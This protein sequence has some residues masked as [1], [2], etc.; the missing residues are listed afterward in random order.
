MTN[1]VRYIIVLMLF[2][3]VILAQD[4]ELGMKV[5]TLQVKGRVLYRQEGQGPQPLKW[6]QPIMPNY[7]LELGPDGYL[8][9]A[10]SVRLGEFTGPRMLMF[11]D[12]ESNLGKK[13]SEKTKDV[14]FLLK[15]FW[16][17]I[18]RLWSMLEAGGEDTL[19]RAAVRAN[20]TRI[21]RQIPLAPRNGIVVGDSIRIIW[22]NEN[23]DMQQ[24]LVILDNDLDLVFQKEVIGR[25][26]ALSGADLRLRPG[27]TY[28]WSVNPPDVGRHDIPFKVA[29]ERLA[30]KVNTEIRQIGGLGRFDSVEEHL[31]KAFVYEKNQCHGNAYYE[32]AS[33]IEADTSSTV[34]GLFTLF[35]V[36]KIG[37]SDL[38]AATVINDMKKR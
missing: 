31:M 21:A 4:N 29:D 15:Y 9:V 10:D 17:Q 22:Y 8:K 36:D 27:M 38:E 30:R 1:A 28:F 3:S 35:L 7:V 19:S 37:L 11:G 18:S 26:T 12:I 2:S 34:V 13:L 32:Y 33:A 25:S 24:R 20:K 5:F 16:G 6:G 23:H 14:G